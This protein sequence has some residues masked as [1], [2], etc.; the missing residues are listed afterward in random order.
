MF[1]GTVVSHV[2]NHL[3]TLER[4]LRCEFLF[5]ARTSKQSTDRDY[6][7]DEFEPY[8]TWQFKRYESS[9]QF[10]F[11][12]II[13]SM[14][15]TD[16][17]EVLCTPSSSLLLVGRSTL[18]GTVLNVMQ[19]LAPPVIIVGRAYLGFFE[20]QRW[21]QRVSITCYGSAVFFWYMLLLL[22]RV[23]ALVTTCDAGDAA[24]VDH[25]FAL[26]AEVSLSPFLIGISFFTCGISYLAGMMFLLPT[27]PGVIIAALKLSMCSGAASA[28]LIVLS[29]TIF[30]IG[31][32][33]FAL[34]NW[35]GHSLHKEH[36]HVRRLHFENLTMQQIAAAEKLR[37]QQAAAAEKL[38]QLHTQEELSNYLM[39]EIRNDQNVIVGA[40]GT[41]IA[42]VESGEGLLSA[43]AMELMNE[44]RAHAYHAARVIENTLMLARLHAGKLTKPPEDNFYVADTIKTT[45]ALAKHMLQAKPAVE[46]R[47]DMAPS[48]PRLCG[49]ADLLEQV[50]VNLVTNAIKYTDHGHVTLAV[51]VHVPELSATVQD[52]EPSEASG[53]VDQFLVLEF[54]VEDTGCGVPSAKQS[55]IFE[56]YE[57]GLR[58]GTGLGIPIVCSLL[59]LMGSKL[60]LNSSPSGGA[61]FS[62]VLRMP[63]AKAPVLPRDDAPLTSQCSD[64]PSVEVNSSITLPEDLVV[65][66][67]DD[68]RANRL[69]LRTSLRKLLKGVSIVDA[70][71]GDQAL[72]LL[73]ERTFDVAILDEHFGDIG[74]LSGT[75]VSRIFRQDY[76]DSA[77][78]IIG[79]TGN[80]GR[81]DHEDL[82]R[83]SGQQATWG[84]P[85]P[86]ANDL[87]ADLARLVLPQARL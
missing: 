82:A 36:L 11:L 72:E 18:L 33:L 19:Y 84:K 44:G 83:Q 87:K 52:E 58:P 16:V 1:G 9:H 62:F 37:L 45:F 78:V 60:L 13:I 48:L 5:G 53:S 7:A 27:V 24:A 55:A 73:R 39:H 65:L 12:F 8:S 25:A 54:S 32:F 10:T 77:M 15:A 2:D 30:A 64:N 71:S 26:W 21:A 38:A 6:C 61:T 79:C 86:N 29:L 35:M 34:L 14:V 51:R 81:S 85:L 68:S 4:W 20:D 66:V 42:E 69:I 50:L 80:T 3:C 23:E 22:E 75:D 74:T 17:Y 31:N 59:E 46:L 41:M 40:F 67:A 57:K 49:A 76:P 43:G 47:I 28:S 63:V 56:P 70:E